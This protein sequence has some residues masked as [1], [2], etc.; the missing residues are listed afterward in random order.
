MTVWESCPRCATVTELDK[1]N[2]FN[3][4]TDTWCSSCGNLIQRGQVA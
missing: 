4:T 2:G 3:E 1:R